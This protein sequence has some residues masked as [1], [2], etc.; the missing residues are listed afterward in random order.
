MIKKIDGMV[1]VVRVNS[2]EKFFKNWPDTFW[3][4]VGR[5]SETKKGAKFH[6][7]KDPAYG[8]VLIHNRKWNFYCPSPSTAPR[9]YEL[10]DR[11]LSFPTAS[12]YWGK[13]RALAFAS[14]SRGGRILSRSCKKWTRLSR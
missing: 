13:I 5:I 3:V 14:Q 9:V 4:A 12:R 7:P 11:V 10:H 1:Q 8:R 2:S 6:E